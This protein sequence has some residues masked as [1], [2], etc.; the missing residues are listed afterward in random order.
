MCVSDLPVEGGEVEGV[1]GVGGDGLDAAEEAVERA[2]ARDAAADGAGGDLGAEAGEVALGVAAGDGVEAE[3]GSVEGGA[4]VAEVRAVGALGVGAAGAGVGGP[5]D[6]EL[7]GLRVGHRD[8]PGGGGTARDVAGRPEC[9]GGGGI[10][11]VPGGLHGR[12]GVAGRGARGVKQP[13]CLTR[14]EEGERPGT[15]SSRLGVAVVGCPMGGGAGGGE[16][17]PQNLDW[18]VFTPFRACPL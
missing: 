1:E 10:A 17:G 15:L 5:C 14:R 8:R 13:I 18:N 7:D 3:A 16:A 2:D 4:E 9:A 12:R 11:G 6:E